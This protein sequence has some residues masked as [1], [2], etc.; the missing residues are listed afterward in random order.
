MKRFFHAGNLKK[1]ERTHTVGKPFKCT[2]FDKSFS[3]SSNLKTHYRIHS[4]GKPFYCTKQRVT[5][6]FSIS[7]FLK[8]HEMRGLTREKPF[9]CSM[10]DKS[11]SDSDHLLKTHERTPTEEMLFQSS[12]CMKTFYQAGNLKKHERTHTEAFQMF[13]V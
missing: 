9:K 1:H 4:G 7:S 11:F 8:E 2:N 10:C 13:K 6:F 3:V 12:K 5:K